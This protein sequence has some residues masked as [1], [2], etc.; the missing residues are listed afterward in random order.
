MLCRT[1]AP[2][3]LVLNICCCQCLQNLPSPEFHPDTWSPALPAPQKEEFVYL[4]LKVCTL[5]V[6]S[7]NWLESPVPIGLGTWLL[8]SS[9]AILTTKHNGE[10]PKGCN[11]CKYSLINK[12]S[13][14]IWGHIKF[15]GII[16]SGFKDGLRGRKRYATGGWRVLAGWRAHE[17]STQEEPVG[18]RLW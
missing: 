18:S 8:K 2:R 11:Q 17:E 6:R 7:P 10:N 12:G 15:L 14:R 9:R 3:F 5:L 13:L 1:Q 4:L 16:I